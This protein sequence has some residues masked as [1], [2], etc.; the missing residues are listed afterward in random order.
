MGQVGQ[1]CKTSEEAPATVR[2]DRRGEAQTYFAHGAEDGRPWLNKSVNC[3]VAM[4]MQI[5]ELCWT[6]EKLCGFP[7]DCSYQG[8]RAILPRPRGNSPVVVVGQHIFKE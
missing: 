8:S 3:V 7:R 2:Q 4:K 5:P 6:G 1:R